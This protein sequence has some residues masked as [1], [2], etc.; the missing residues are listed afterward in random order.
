[1]KK[2]AVTFSV[3]TGAALALTHQDADASTQHTVQ[4]GESLWSIADQYGVSVD[5]IKQDNNLSNNMLFPD[6]LFL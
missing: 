3:A 6:K 5:S 4:S 2:L 1:M